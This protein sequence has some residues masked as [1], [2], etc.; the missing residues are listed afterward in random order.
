MDK[1]RVALSKY[2]T[3]D[4]ICRIKIIEKKNLLERIEILVE[5]YI[6]H[7]LDRDPKT[8]LVDKVL[9]I[10]GDM[11]NCSILVNDILTK[12]NKSLVESPKKVESQEV[13]S[14]GGKSQGGKSPGVDLREKTA[15]NVKTDIINNSNLDLKDCSC[16]GPGYKYNSTN[17]TCW[18]KT[19]GDSLDVCIP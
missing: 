19:T 3:E 11:P 10:I 13:K 2:I 17:N 12:T 9:N 7:N 8:K 6:H 5:N 16:R 1:I 15:L 4:E 14:Q 18:N